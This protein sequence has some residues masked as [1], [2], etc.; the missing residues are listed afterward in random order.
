M[1]CVPVAISA[2]NKIIRPIRKAHPH[3]TSNEGVEE[4]NSYFQHTIVSKP[5]KLAPFST[6][7]SGTL[8]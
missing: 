1:I 4:E 8:R 7:A 5:C 6:T 3:K 2:D